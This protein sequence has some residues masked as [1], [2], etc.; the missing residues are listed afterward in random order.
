MSHLENIR[1][2]LN[3][4]KNCPAADISKYFAPASDLF[5]LLTKKE[6][7]ECAQ[8]FY[9]W[10]EENAVREPLKFCY[11]KF[12][13][14]LNSFL[15]EQH[16]TALHLVTEARSRFEEQ[17]DRIGIGI[18][19]SLM[20]GIYR[21][22]GNIDLAL[23][24]LWESYSLLKQSGTYS[25]FLS[26]CT[27][28]MANIYLEMHNHDEALLMFKLTYEQCEKNNDPFWIYYALHGLGKVY[29]LQHKYH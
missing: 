24:T 23:K 28:N 26:A 5:P 21:T 17:N 6:Q 7:N 9:H 12:L 15:C 2:L 4:L 1:E 14:A 22:L 8:T 13:F 19:A 20:G 11:A 18:C 27:C 29:M 3:E 25:H 10:A 16:E